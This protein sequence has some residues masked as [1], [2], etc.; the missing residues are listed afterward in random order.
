MIEI[1]LSKGRIADNFLDLLVKK[2]LID[3]KP[4][5]DRDYTYENSVLKIMVARSSDLSKLLDV[6]RAKVAVLGSDVIEEKYK[7]RYIEIMDLGIGKCTFVL[8]GL[9]NTNIEEIKRIATKYPN[10]A[11][12]Y[13]KELK[14]QCE[15]EKMNGCLELYPK[16]GYSD[17]IIDLVETGKT[18][19]ANGLVVLKR[20]EPISTRVITTKENNDNDEVKKFVYSLR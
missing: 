12:K 9:P 8:A 17:G 4:N 20:F 6:N 13:L 16:I 3:K 14:L 2:E 7:D 1:V 5:M 10:I 18:L 19:E 15:I 11:K